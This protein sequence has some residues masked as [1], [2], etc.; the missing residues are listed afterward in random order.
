MNQ[1][2]LGSFIEAL[3]NVAIGLVVSIVA[4]ALVF[5]RFGFRPSLGE[6][7]AISAIYTVISIV[8]SY[9]VRRFFNAQL[10]AAARRLAGGK[11]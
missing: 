1:T 5:P 7:V 11:P 8:R 3:L 2:R 6:N 10:H 9:L 4:N